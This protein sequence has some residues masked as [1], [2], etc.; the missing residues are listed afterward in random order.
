MNFNLRGAI[1]DNIRGS[2]EQEI[3]ATIKDAM[4]RGE[5]KMLPGLGVLLEVYWNNA[6]EDQRDQL[7][8]QISNGLQ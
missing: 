8:Q 5:E 6:S 7:C 4:Q 1:L 2:S 3:E